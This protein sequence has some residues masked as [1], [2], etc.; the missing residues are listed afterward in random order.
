MVAGF[1]LKIKDNDIVPLNK[2]QHLLSS[3]RNYPAATPLNCALINLFKNAC[4]RNNSLS[5]LT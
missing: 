2:E 5:L 4:Q 3:Q 1:I